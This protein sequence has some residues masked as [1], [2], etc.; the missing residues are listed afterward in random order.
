MKYEDCE[1]GLQ[2][3]HR[4]KRTADQWDLP[5]HKSTLNHQQRES[6]KRPVVRSGT[7]PQNPVLT[8]ACWGWRP[9][10]LCDRASEHS[11][12]PA[13]HQRWINFHHPEGKLAAAFW[14]KE[15]PASPGVL[16]SSISQ[17]SERQ[18]SCIFVKM[19]RKEMWRAR[20]P[21]D[22]H[23]MQPTGVLFPTLQDLRCCVPLLSGR[24]D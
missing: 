13:D 14:Q 7:P 18:P 9:S 2:D 8:P 17:N 4:W 15:N 23:S 22:H 1:Y 20:P 16:G 11:G 24:A 3:W 21:V 12:I 6:Q 10:S 5:P 19:Q